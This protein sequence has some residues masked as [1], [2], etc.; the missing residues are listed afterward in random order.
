MNE[1]LNYIFTAK[2]QI[3]SLLFEHI[4][5]TAL[6]VGI[7]I[8]IG[9][10]LGI[11]TSYVKKLN[12]P[13]LGIASVVQAIP[14]MALL[15]FAIP[16]LGIGT[17]PA[18][19]MVVLYSLLPIIK[20]TT[21]GI[22]NINPD[23]IE[24]SKGIGLTKFQVLV[25]VQIP[26]ALPVIMSG[27]RISAVTAVGLMTMAAFIGGGGLGYLVFSGIRTVN[28]Y[29]I[30]AGAIPA[31]ILAL[32]VDGL[33]SIVEKLVT[34]ISLQKSN[35]KSKEAK[36]KARKIQKTILGATA[37]ILAGIFVVTGVSQ[38]ISSKKVITIGSKDFTEQEILGNILSELI[39]RK[40]D[41]SVNRK[42][43]L[44]GTQVIFSAMKS[45]D[46]DMYVSYS[47]TAYGDVLKY[48]PISDVEKVYDTVKKDYKDKYNLDVLKQMGFN[49]TYTLA[50]T[51]ETAKKYNLKT[52]SDLSKVSNELTATTTLEFLNRE[53]GLIGLTKKYNLNFK[54]TVGIDGS[55]RYAA[56]INKESDVVDAFSTDGLL[57]KYDLSVLKDDKNFFPPYYAI[58]VIRDETLKKYPEIQ[59]LVEKVGDLL[60]D[61]VMSEL[62]YEVD[63]LKK[64]PKDVAVDFLEKNGL[65]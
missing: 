36:I 13:I 38:K 50:V 29:Q 1:F 62:N 53:D 14:S 7:A 60:N 11:L 56:L 45:G 41:I 59:P 20:N 2:E 22:D 8:I 35:N 54:N 47:G 63:E 46:V 17:P 23:M 18:I 32:L 30:L 3:I 24:A 43:A 58:P 9:M 48:K 34:P 25:K 6:S 44:G 5:L 26:L 52:I 51:K 37:C 10:P 28:N 40:T 61:D 31:C 12:K 55:P 15:G 33:F 49:N 42:F 4:K 65:I 19:V 27:I 64:D 16:F 57:K 21:T 39:E